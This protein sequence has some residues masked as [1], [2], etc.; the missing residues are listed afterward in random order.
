MQSTQE[1]WK[2]ISGYEGHYEVSN[3]GNIR[4]LER[5]YYSG[6]YKN[7]KKTV[8]AGPLFV[9]TD[10]DGYRY[11]K[12]TKDG[13]RSWKRLNRL[14]CATFKDNP[15]NKP[16]V[17]HKNGIKWDDRSDNLEWCT[18]SEN[19]LHSFRELSRKP[20]INMAGKPAVNRRRVTQL[21]L[22]GSLVKTYEYIKLVEAD[23]FCSKKVSAVALGQRNKHGGFRWEYA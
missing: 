5:V 21:T 6:E 10:K 12:L 11:T 15:D 8:S 2:S 17:N 20:V 3:L 23:G 19:M 16:Y 4:T 18:A 9:K 22:S 13:N 7:I 14:V 1:I